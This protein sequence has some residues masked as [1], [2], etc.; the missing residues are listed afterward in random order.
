M[1]NFAEIEAYILESDN[2]KIWTV[3]ANELVK[4]LE[5]MRKDQANQFTCYRAIVKYNV[6]D[7]NEFTVLKVL[8]TIIKVK[9]RT[10]Q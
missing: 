6:Q 7:K 1:N 10:I 9:D 3:Q 8:N 4:Q 2:Q 5:E